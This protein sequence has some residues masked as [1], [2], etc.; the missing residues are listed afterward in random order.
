VRHCRMAASRKA[1]RRCPRCAG[2]AAAHAAALSAPPPCPLSPPAASLPARLARTGSSRALS[3]SR[4]D[5][6]SRQCCS[7]VLIRVARI[8][9][10]AAASPRRAAGVSL[11]AAGVSAACPLRATGVSLFHVAVSDD[12]RCILAPSALVLC[13][14]VLCERESDEPPESAA[15][16][17]IATRCPRRRPALHCSNVIGPTRKLDEFESVVFCFWFQICFFSRPSRE[18]A[19]NA[20]T[21]RA[22]AASVEIR[23]EEGPH[24]YCASDQVL[25]L[26]VPARKRCPRPISDVAPRALRCGL[27]CRRAAATF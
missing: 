23:R 26:P 7:A 27:Q 10:R 17:T 24:A 15:C 2:M 6:L 21:G 20:A 5:G 11:R 16:S 13:A 4:E 19:L 18:R 12:V 22:T 1:P 3:A 9:R 14:A 25:V 8:P